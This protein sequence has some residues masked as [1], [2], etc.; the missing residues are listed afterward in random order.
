[1]LSHAVSLLKPGGKL[2]VISFHSL[3]DRIVK[4][5]LRDHS[6]AI[7]DDPTWP[8]PR[9]NPDYH[10]DLPAKLIQA[11]PEEASQNPRAR[12]AKLRF[13]VRRAI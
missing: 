8:E 11:T 5:F 2:A 3:E 9:P 12:S 4:R 10:F 7:V 13:A 6:Q 1:M